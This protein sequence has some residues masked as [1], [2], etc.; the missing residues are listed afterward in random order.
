MHQPR[1]Q[2][3]R[4]TDHDATQT[5]VNSSLVTHAVSSGGQPL[6]AATRERLEPRFGHSFEDVRVFADE[7]A[8]ESAE[9]LGANAF[10]V[11]SDIVFAAGRYDPHSSTGQQLLAH[12]LSHT[13]QQGRHGSGSSRHLPSEL[14]VSHRDDA[15]ESEAD[16]AANAVSSGRNAQVTAS[17]SEPSIARDEN[18]TGHHAHPGILDRIFGLNPD[19]SFVEA[20]MDPMFGKNGVFTPQKGDGTGMMTAKALGTAATMPLWGGPLFGAIGLDEIN[21]LPLVAAA[22]GTERG[23]NG[24]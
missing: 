2:L 3:K 24:R 9:A 15:S 13:I 20:Y 5:R 19:R 16:T 11:G 1:I 4:S 10:A 7:R 8:A 22:Q 17:T 21:H 12:E 18:E 14:E 6:D 23:L